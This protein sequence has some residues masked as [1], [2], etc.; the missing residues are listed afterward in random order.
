[1]IHK[2]DPT[3][4]EQRKFLLE[5]IDFLI[6]ASLTWEVQSSTVGIKLPGVTTEYIIKN[7]EQS[8][9]E[10]KRLVRKKFPTTVEITDQ[11]IKNLNYKISYNFLKKLMEFT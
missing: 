5:E 8:L 6:N 7:D 11:D 1:M 9:I 10:F 3:L 4:V 2:K